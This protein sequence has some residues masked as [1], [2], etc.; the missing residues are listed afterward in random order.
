MP[1]RGLLRCAGGAGGS[2]LRADALTVQG[3]FCP[4]AA[5]TC[6]A[7]SVEARRSRVHYGSAQGAS[8]TAADRLTL[9]GTVRFRA[10]LVQGRAFGLLPLS[11][12]TAALPPLP[13]PFLVLTNV[14][15]RGLW[16]RAGHVDAEAMTI[17]APGACGEVGEAREAVAV[18]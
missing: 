6:R 5:G 13:V 10:S 15:M 17:G 2:D 3:L 7:T 14:T 18:R 9:T 12:S 4:P 16:A 11:L 8:C 1:D